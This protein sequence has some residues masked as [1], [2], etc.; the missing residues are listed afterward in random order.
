M[1]VYIFIG[2]MNSV[3]MISENVT[4]IVILPLYNIVYNY[5]LET[6]PSAY[7]IIS[8]CLTVPLLGCFG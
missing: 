8:L 2:S 4:K 3:K 5:T 6:M 1:C 7:F